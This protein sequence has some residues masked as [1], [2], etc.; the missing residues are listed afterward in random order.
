MPTPEVTLRLQSYSSR[1]RFSDK[2]VLE[3]HR[4]TDELRPWLW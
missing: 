4:G 2:V 3:Y 1:I